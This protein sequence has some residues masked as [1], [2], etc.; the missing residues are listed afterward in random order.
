M[1]NNFFTPNG[2]GVNDLWKIDFSI[3][4]EGIEL[5]IFDRYGKFLKQLFG[6]DPGW[7]GTFNGHNQIADDYWFVVTRANGKEYRGHF[8]LKR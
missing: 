7:D 4:E 6:E 8:A 5:R 1:Y 2:D 3:F